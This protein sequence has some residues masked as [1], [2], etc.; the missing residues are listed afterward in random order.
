MYNLA[1]VHCGVYN[2]SHIFTHFVTVGV[3][4]FVNFF[5]AAAALL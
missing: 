5:L 4:I 3:H 1:F 2:S